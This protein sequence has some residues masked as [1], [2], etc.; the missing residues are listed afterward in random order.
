MLLVLGLAVTGSLAPSAS[1]EVPS[2]GVTLATSATHAVSVGDVTPGCADGSANGGSRV[3]LSDDRGATWAAGPCD[4][5]IVGGMYLDGTTDLL[6]YST[7]GSVV[8]LTASGTVAADVPIAETGAEVVAADRSYA[9]IGAGNAIIR[10]AQN[11]STY[12]CGIPTGGAND[13]IEITGMADGTIVGT[14]SLLRGDI[15]V[16]HDDCGT[17]TPIVAAAPCGDVRSIGPEALD[18]T[19]PSTNIYL[20]VATETQVP[21]LWAQAATSPDRGQLGVDGSHVE[22][23][24]YMSTETVPAT[25]PAPLPYHAEPTP[26]DPFPS[27][28][29]AAAIGAIDRTM[30]APVGLPPITWSALAALAAAN[31][32]IEWQL[33]GVLP[34]PMQDSETPGAP[35][36]TG[37]DSRDRCST[38][39]VGLC[40]EYPGPGMPDP[41]A[42]ITALLGDPYF[43][44]SMLATTQ[45]GIGTSSAGSVVVEPLGTQ[46]LVLPD[47]TR[48]GFQLDLSLPVNTPSSLL[49]VWPA[50]GTTNVA[51]TWTRPALQ[52][53]DPQ[54][55]YDGPGPVGPPIL[56]VGAEQA[57]YELLDPRGVPVDL[58]QEGFTLATTSVT[59][60][61][62]LIA[63]PTSALTPGATYTIDVR[64]LVGPHEDLHFT[65]A[66][67]T[68]Q[69][70]SPKTTACT[71][72]LRQARTASAVRL[73]ITAHSGTCAGVRIQW[74]RR[75]LRPW[76]RLPAAG[77]VAPAGRVLYWRA[78]HG[79]R[80]VLHGRVQLR[81]RAS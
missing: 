59:A 48:P 32:A 55:L 31:H 79:T 5:R 7:G 51:S 3:L 17:F 16:S 71:V 28:K 30:R 26:G 2:S 44:L 45:L 19:T 15:L 29:I 69:T 11:G 20:D 66:G 49:R 34:A 68:R 80:V 40:T 53:N 23:L 76:R 6:A 41:T 18:C 46:G 24:D 74:R 58:L 43:E 81:R 52:L 60:A 1:A 65:V 21:T 22:T 25:W 73:T 70:T 35:G 72:S 37:A 10:V 14:S 8:W 78:V 75:A 9:Y 42:V 77:L 57:T 50:N 36:F 64:P 33:A 4:P 13:R 39:G 54:K 12:Q 27:S 62:D 61:G 63:Y 56:A 67:G 47:L 38:V